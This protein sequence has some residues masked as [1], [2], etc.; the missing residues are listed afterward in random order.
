MEQVEVASR[1]LASPDEVWQR[2]VTPDGINYE[3]RPWLRMT[4]PRSLRNATVENV[5]LGAPLGRSWIL[6]LGAIPFD[7]DDLMIAELEVGRRFLETSRTLSASRWEHERTITPT[8]DGTEIRDRLRFEPRGLVA[9]T[10]RIVRVVVSWIF[11][12]RHRRLVRY[13]GAPPTSPR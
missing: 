3:L 1:V 13:F 8:N 7:Y 10:P 12:H 5:P 4:V 9:Q 2:I 6:F 11:R